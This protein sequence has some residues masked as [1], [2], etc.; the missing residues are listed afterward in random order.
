MKTETSGFNLEN[1]LDLSWGR[2]F[3]VCASVVGLYYI[4]YLALLLHIIVKSGT[5]FF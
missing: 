3:F 2:P 4:A 1:K 5:H